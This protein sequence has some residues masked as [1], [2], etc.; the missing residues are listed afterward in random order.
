MRKV[1]PIFSSEYHLLL[2]LRSGLRGPYRQTGT[3][4]STTGYWLQVVEAGMAIGLWLQVNDV[5]QQLMTYNH[6][7][8]PNLQPIT[9]VPFHVA[10]TDTGFVTVAGSTDF[11]ESK[12]G[13]P[14]K[15]EPHHRR[16]V[17]WFISPYLLPPEQYQLLWLQY[18]IF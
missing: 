5:T 13:A 8:I 4:K 12:V 18:F 3:V 15:K 14:N 9:V 1:S 6:T 7:G 10:I 11:F 2:R 17:I 16:N